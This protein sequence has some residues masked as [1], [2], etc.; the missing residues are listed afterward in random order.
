[1]KNI[2]LYDIKEI[3]D[4]LLP[5][6]YTRPVSLIRIGILTIKEKWQRFFNGDAEISFI[7]SEYLQK[8]FPSNATN[9]NYFIA[10]HIL[11]TEELATQI[12]ALN[13]GEALCFN[14]TEKGEKSV[15]AFRCSKS[16]YKRGN[17]TPTIVVDNCPDHIRYLYDI[18][19]KNGEQLQSDF[20][21][22]TA[23][24]KSQPISNTNTIIGN[25][26]CE[27]GS[28]K[29]FIEE[30]ASVEGAF[31][32]VN[33]GPIYIGKDAEIM[34]GSCVRGPFA[35]CNNAHV[36]MGAKIYG[37]TTLGPFCKVGGE[38]SNVVM[39]G[40]SNKGHDGFLGNA[41]IGEWCNIGAGAS[42]SN[43]KNDY[44]EIKLW[45]YPATR[46]LRT[47]LQF[48]GLIMGDHTKVGVNCMLNTATVLGVG[49]NI[50]GAGFP[51]NFVPSFSEGSAAGFTDVS[52]TKFFQIAERMMARRDQVLTD[53]DREIF[54]HIYNQADAYK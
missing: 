54:T 6:T 17:I 18:F 31:L 8:K 52:L 49:V 39:Q 14:D 25:Q 33:A 15:I 35:A 22:I 21:L 5:L 9:D 16:D 44:T 28:P 27:D 43:L 47:G 19:I 4:N 7:T 2:I 36:N 32:N 24:R 46:F 1:M 50:H 40:F 53:A 26:S 30:G 41:V 34:E 3:R 38:L 29:I 37:P 45:N 10:S 11:P 23:N 13:P 20:K 48:C 51:R 12:S 42:A